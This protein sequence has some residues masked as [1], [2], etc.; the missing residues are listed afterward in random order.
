MTSLA[1]RSRQAASAAASCGLSDRLPDSTSVNSATMRQLPLSKRTT[2]LHRRD[3][4]LQNQPRG[5]QVTFLGRLRDNLRYLFD[6]LRQYV[7]RQYSRTIS[8]T[9]R[10]AWIT[11][12]KSFF[13]EVLARC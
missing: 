1:P 4:A 11:L 5:S 8:R 2:R 9:S 3:Q 6:V 7:L 10:A 13:C 12:L